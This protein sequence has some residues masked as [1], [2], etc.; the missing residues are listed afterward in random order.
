MH[1][2]A[3][4]QFYYSNVFCFFFFYLAGR[5]CCHILISNLYD[6]QHNFDPLIVVRAE[7]YEKSI[8]KVRFKAKLT[9]SLG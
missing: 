9:F 6:L 3:K 4:E 1:F 7:L 5:K 8:L 2:E